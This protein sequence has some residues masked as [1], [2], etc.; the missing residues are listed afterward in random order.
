MRFS[1][2]IISV[3]AV[4]AIVAMTG[5]GEKKNR[6]KVQEN[7]KTRTTAPQKK[8]SAMV[9]RIRDIDH[10]TTRLEFHPEYAVFRKIRQPIVMITLLGDW[11]PQCRGMLP[12]LSMLQK[13]NSDSLFVIGVLVN[14]DLDDGQL[15]RFM[16]RYESNFFISNHPDNNR[17]GYFLAE[18]Y[19]LGDNY[20]LP[21][22]LFFKNGKYIM[23]ISGAVPYE[24]LQD[25]VDQLKKEE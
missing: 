12:Y 4:S 8:P 25:I 11:C 21:L 22:T 13:K 6:G 2:R 24:M 20:P 23:H 3:L 18:K 10:R 15:R 5:C 14:S 9:F 19:G 17:L 1:G 16:N 7:A